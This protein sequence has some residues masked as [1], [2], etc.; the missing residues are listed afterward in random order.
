MGKFHCFIDQSPASIEDNDPMDSPSLRQRQGGKIVST[1]GPNHI[2]GRTSHV[3][4][5]CQ[6][7]GGAG[8]ISFGCWYSKASFLAKGVPIAFEQVN[9]VNAVF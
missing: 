9:K 7:G 4:I 8:G 5:I 3:P 6:I 1:P 2:P